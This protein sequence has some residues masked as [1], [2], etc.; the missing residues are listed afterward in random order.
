MTQSLEARMGALEKTQTATATRDLH[1]LAWDLYKRVWCQLTPEERAS[2]CG[3]DAEAAE[4]AWRAAVAAHYGHVSVPDLARAAPLVDR[5]IILEVRDELV[6]N[7]KALG[8]LDKTATELDA[9]EAALTR[10]DAMYSAPR[11]VL[12]RYRRR[13]DA[14]ERAAQTDPP[15]VVLYEFCGRYYP[16]LV[17]AESDLAGGAVDPAQCGQDHPVIL[18]PYVI[19][20]ERELG[21]E[22]TT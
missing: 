3:D 7:P 1:A 17:V 8:M 4:R 10:H 20:D 5:Q 9:L 19:A 18:V 6:F 11:F 22:Q 13:L 15:G 14:L 2:V 21:W 12:S 16:E